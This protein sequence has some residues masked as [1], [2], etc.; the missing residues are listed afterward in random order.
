VPYSILCGSIYA[1]TPIEDIK[2]EKEKEKDKDND[3]HPIIETLMSHGFSFEI[4]KKCQAKHGVK[5]IE[6]NLAYT[7]A[8]KQEGKVSDVPA[9]LNKAIENDYGSAWDIENQKKVEAE[10]KAKKEKAEKDRLEQVQKSKEEQLS[11]ARKIMYQDA[12]DNF[13]KLPVEQQEAIKNEFIQATDSF[14]VK[15][16]KE[17]EKNNEPWFTSPMVSQN[18]KIFLS[19][20]E[21]K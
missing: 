5:K 10:L 11:Q 2:P 20:R 1:P 15:R 6:R 7:L 4:A 21:C 16:M 14:T 13:L 12:F 9:Y 8:K 17:S 18:F 19:K 3:N